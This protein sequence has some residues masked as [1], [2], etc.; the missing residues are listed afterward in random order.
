MNEIYELLKEA[1][2]FFIATVDGDQPHVRVFGATVMYNN[3]IYIHTGLGKPV[4]NQ[5]EANPKVEICTFA[6]GKMMRITAKVNHDPSIEAQQAML[7]ANPSLTKMYA[8]NDGKNSVW[9][10]SDIKA[11]VAMGPNVREITVE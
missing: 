10:L 5:M 6:K 4:A 11:T 7:D 3:K 8:V 9:Y 2:I 1:G